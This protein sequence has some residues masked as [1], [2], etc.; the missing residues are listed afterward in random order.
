MTDSTENHICTHCE[1][2]H[3]ETAWGWTLRNVDEVPTAVKTLPDGRLELRIQHPVLT[4][5]TPEMLAWWFQVVDGYTNYRGKT[6][7]TYHLWHPQDHVSVRVTRDADGQVAPGQTMT[8]HEVLGGNPNHVIDNTVTI[9]RLDTGGI[10]IHGDL[11][12]HRVM[13]L[14]HTFTAV[15][16]GV[17]Y[18]S[19]MRLGAGTGWFHRLFNQLFLP[20]VF[21]K[22]K[23]KAWLKHNVEEV[24]CFVNFLPEIYRHREAGDTARTQQNPSQESV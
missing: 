10:G 9:H 16:G 8:I 5:V 19:V 12:G 23:A 24:G 11:L 14:D 4:G 1:H 21:S 18:E 20:L 7:R 6:Y 13:S 22:A 17:K 15:E 3:D 2:G